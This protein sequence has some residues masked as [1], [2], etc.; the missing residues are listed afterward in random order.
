[1]I[2]MQQVAREFQDLQHTIDGVAEITAM[3]RERFLLVPQYVANEEMKKS[4][5]HKMLRSNI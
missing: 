5:Y 3:F 2:E 4:W 1:M